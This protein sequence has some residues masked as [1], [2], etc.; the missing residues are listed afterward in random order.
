MNWNTENSRPVTK[1]TNITA[2][3]HLLVYFRFFINLD[4]DADTGLANTKKQLLKKIDKH[5][6]HAF[7]NHSS[8]KS[9]FLLTTGSVSFC[10]WQ[11]SWKFSCC[12]TFRPKKFQPIILYSN[13]PK[14][15]IYSY[16]SLF[17]LLNA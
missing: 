5:Q 13:S 3:P 4:F 15:V 17:L 8:Q 12:L 1:T 6:H 2:S 10:I 16:S 9:G 11:S 7:D 14:L